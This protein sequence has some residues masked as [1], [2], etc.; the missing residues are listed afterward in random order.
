MLI[1]MHPAILSTLAA[2]SGV[3]LT[4][5]SLPPLVTLVDIIES[6]IAQSLALLKPANQLSV[7]NAPLLIIGAGP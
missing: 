4:Q 5:P 7:L 3:G 6:A 2:L 1:T